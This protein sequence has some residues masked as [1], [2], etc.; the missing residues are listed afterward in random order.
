MRAFPHSKAHP[1][2]LGATPQLT[3][4]TLSSASIRRKRHQSAMG[5]VMGSGGLS[6][7]FPCATSSLAHS[8]ATIHLHDTTH[9]VFMTLPPYTSTREDEVQPLVSGVMRHPIH[10]WCLVEHVAP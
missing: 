5:S 10:V 4:L 9:G 2:G 7:A 6:Y 1:A 3:R 8:Q